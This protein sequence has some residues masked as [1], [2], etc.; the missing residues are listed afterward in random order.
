MTTTDITKL[1]AQAQ[2]LRQGMR[3]AL[4]KANDV[5]VRKL[6]NELAAVN[7]QILDGQAEAQVD[8]R[9]EYMGNMHD[10]LS[11]FEVPGM[12]LTVT[13]M[14]NDGKTANSVIFTPTYDTIEAITSV[15]AA[16]DRPSTAVKWTFSRDEMG[17]PSFDFGKGP[18]KPGISSNGTRSVGWTTPDGTAI[19]LGDAFNVCATKAQK[20][21]LDS[22]EGGSAT[23][24]FKTKTVTAAGYKKA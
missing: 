4:D 1:T 20:F 12:T 13:S 9:T 14:V 16:I 11:A 21:E 24:A 19:T 6:S 10:A 15:I 17:E 3:E 5:A 22:K 18:R 2:E 7:K 23:N 8:A